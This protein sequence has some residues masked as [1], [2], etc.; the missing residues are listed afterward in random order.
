MAP[1]LPSARGGERRR[2]TGG[3][4]LREVPADIAHGGVETG[5]KTITQH[6]AER[7]GVLFIMLEGTSREPSPYC[8]MSR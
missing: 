2:V 1:A 8:A 5:T 6:D 7:S 4:G 3:A